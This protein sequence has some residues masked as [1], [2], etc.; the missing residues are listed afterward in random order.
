M[1][2]AAS[3]VDR[4]R[5]RA[6]ACAPSLGLVLD[7][8]GTL[9][10]LGPTPS[11]VGPDDE[12]RSL[13][14]SLIAAPRTRV[15]IVSGRPRDELALMLDGVRGLWLVAE[16]GA[17]RRDDDV[18]WSMAPVT[19]EPPD[20]VE[21]ALR[22]VA[23]SYENTLVERKRWSVC[24]HY[25]LVPP[26]HR[27]ALV[28][29]ATNVANELL[30]AH[31][32]YELLEA[33][34]ALEVRHRQVHKGTA[35][36]W[37]RSRMEP[38]T[39]V[40]AIGDDVT[41]EDAFAALAPDDAAIVVG[42]ERSRPTRARAALA[43]SASVRRFL[44]WLIAVR[45][46]TAPQAPA[47]PWALRQPSRGSARFI[48]LSNR[49]PGDD[50]HGDPRRRN[51]G[52]L[53]SALA[54][55]LASRKGSWV[56]WNGQVG[57]A[58]NAVVDTA[59]DAPRVYLSLPREHHELYYNGFCNQ[60]LWPLFHGFPGRVR[61]LDEEW[62]AYVEV[63]ERFADVAAG[64]AHPDATIWV[65]DFHLLLVAHALRRRGFRGRVGFFLHVPFPPIDLL[66]T[67]PWARELVEGALEF[68]LVG[69]HT[70][71]YADNFR[72]A[73]HQLL[74]AR[75]AGGDVEWNGRRTRV[76][77]FPLGIV[78]D[79]FTAASD[80]MDDGGELQAMIDSL[81]GRRLVLGVDRLDYTK[82]IPERLAAFGRMLELFPEWRGRV[83][84]VQIAVPSRA[85]VPEYAEQRRRIEN[86]V[87]RINGEHGEAHWVPVRYLY[88]AYATE[89]L[90][91]LYRA[92]DVGYVTPLRDGMNLVAF[93]YVAAQAPACPGVLL[94]SRFAG[95]A[96]RLSAALLTNP[97][98]CD[99]LARDLHR[100]LQMPLEERQARH[101]ALSAEVGRWTAPAWGQAFIEA[102]EG[103]PC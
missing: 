33:A 103:A 76:G 12:A 10:P 17:W 97:Y 20:A 77:V 88:R 49:V 1:H 37:M 32:E 80:D 7:L 56:G 61:Y 92:A 72:T 79:H 40:V 11:S 84:L 19:G 67:M 34:E 64:M 70:H 98:Q 55:V 95:A 14:A 43:D 35:V 30:A 2:T 41:D 27:E 36:E 53:V 51:V 60:S 73:A 78:P 94:L 82:G 52:G 83:S 63:N 29:H 96:E 44:Q 101:A 87:G 31:P 85:D 100:A 16:H 24:L 23:S 8:D 39:R 102:L 48:V 21:R 3:E 9:I 71:R 65:Q 69:F 46:G 18:H 42:M 26:T 28:V 25:R 74:G 66:E 91:R 6:L 81:A 57:E 99:G 4:E 59:G 58:K 68:D 62:R 5:W 54:P 47:G 75:A 13:L 22:E 89:Q 93:E 15:A 45:T 90:A 38:G 50:T 86:A